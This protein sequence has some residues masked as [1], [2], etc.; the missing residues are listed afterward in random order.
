M[1]KC[2]TIFCLLVVCNAPAQTFEQKVEGMLLGSVIG[3][4]A[5]APYEF[6][7]PAQRSR[8]TTSNTQL[9][10][11]G[12]KALKN[13]FTLADHFRKASSFGPWRDYAQRGTITDDTRL[14]IIFFNAL[15]HQ[16][17]I[18]S[19]HLAKEILNFE[20]R[21]PESS[22]P[23]C[24]DWLEELKQAARWQLGHRSDALPADRLWAGTP[25]NLGQ[26]ALIPLAA[27]S[28]NDLSKTYQKAWELDFLDHGLAR[29]I[30]AAII[31]GLA[32]ALRPG[33]SWQSI[34]AA[35]LTTDPYDYGNSRYGK[36]ALEHWLELAHQMVEKANGN[37]AE[38]FCSLEENLQAQYWWE[39]WVPLVVVFACAEVAEYEPLAAMQLCIEFG[40]D[41]D[42]Y[43]Q[44]MGAFMGALHGPDI[45]PTNMK[46]LIDHR[47]QTDYKVHLGAWTQLLTK[48]LP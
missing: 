33:A 16:P 46:Q 48:H 13:R 14:K 38:L 1:K 36:R 9:D 12:L 11:T 45:F 20:N 24:N 28:T 21:L 22:Q 19:T 8:W 25:G 23:M 32:T 42:S 29:D 3:D 15:R 10:E 39:C 40:H 41:T 37:A 30:N 5:G 44:L 2:F 18:N 43:T 4:A 26:M 7:Y 6:Y 17:E 34:E 35:M 31:T 27:L 47:L